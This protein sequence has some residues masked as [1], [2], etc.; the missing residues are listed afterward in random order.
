MNSQHMLKGGW[1]QLQLSTELPAGTPRWPAAI[2]VMAEQYSTRVSE[3]ITD[4]WWKWKQNVRN[5]YTWLRALIHREN[6]FQFVTLLLD[7]RALSSEGC[8]YLI[9]KVNKQLETS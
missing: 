8:R 7:T 6:V 4:N 3:N 9:R 2:C 5:V 1:Q